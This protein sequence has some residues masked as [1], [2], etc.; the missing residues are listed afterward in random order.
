MED[1]YL[2][3]RNPSRAL[4]VFSIPIILGGLF[5]Q[6]YTM[7]DSALVGQFVGEKA[8]A[9]IGSSFA[10]TTVFI[11][12]AMG[13]GVGA[14]VIVSKH[15]GSKNYVKMKETVWTSL[16]SFLILSIVLSIF[17]IIFGEQI[18]LLL[19]TPSD[20]LNMALL[21]L[22][23]YFVGLPF[24]FMY[25]IIASIF[26][27]LGKSKIPLYFLIFSS[28]VNVIL[29]LIFIIQ[30]NLGVQG[31]AWATLIA[32]GLSAIL[33]FFYLVKQL[34]NFN[35]EYYHFFD[36]HTLKKISNIALPSIFQQSTVSIGML[37]LQSVVNGFGSEVL[38]GYTAAMR[39]ESLLIVPM[40]SLGT[41]ISSFVAQ[42]IGAN[43]YKRVLAG[44]K[45][46]AM[47]IIIC[48][49]LCFLIID[50]FDEKLIL[51]FLGSKGTQTAVSTGYKCLNF[52]MY[53]YVF[54]GFKNITDGLLRGAGD[55]KIFTIANIINLFIRVFGAVTFAPIYGVAVVWFAV[56]VGWFV[57]WVLSYVRYKSGNWQNLLEN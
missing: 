41:S 56:P 21:F 23:I 11:C 50:I 51:I 47:I 2:I 38:A 57:N 27:S 17:G 24:L 32:Q 10:L 22:R 16:I 25:N 4:L 40:A 48:A 9:A 33:S 29:D 18:L 30:F 34:Q 54:F 31:A 14:S 45:S 20:V 43:D 53:F 15:F 52:M 8:L 3:K 13:G 7:V 1:N 5:Q 12:I 46:A 28:I 44:F 36:T 42:N 37:L 55:M 6:A 35:T 26:N 19:N 39:I 49:L